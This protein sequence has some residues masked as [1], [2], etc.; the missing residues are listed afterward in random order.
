MTHTVNDVRIVLHDVAK[1]YKLKQKISH[2]TCRALKR[3]RHSH[4]VKRVYFTRKQRY[5]LNFEPTMTHLNFLVKLS[6][7]QNDTPSLPSLPKITHVR[8]FDFLNANCLRRGTGRVTGSLN[9][10]DCI[11]DGQRCHPYFLLHCTS[12]GWQSH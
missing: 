8:K 10:Y 9:H 3:N 2:H 7:V 1:Y 6:A 5:H 4:Q 12:C 11:K